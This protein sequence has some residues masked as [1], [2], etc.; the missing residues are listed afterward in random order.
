MGWKNTYLEPHSNSFTEL[1]QEWA[2]CSGS[3]IVSQRIYA[4]ESFTN[5]R[6]PAARLSTLVR[7]I[8]IPRLDSA[9]TWEYLHWQAS[10]PRRRKIHTSEI[11]WDAVR[12]LLRR[13][14][15]R[16]LAVIP[17][18]ELIWESRRAYSYTVGN[19]HSMCKEHLT[20][21]DFSRTSNWQ[22]GGVFLFFFV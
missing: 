5:I 18:Q 9:N 2:T 3:K 19:L 16:S 10:N 14:V 7:Q 21:W 13:T 20:P 17:P 6:V 11:I 8:A 15:S 1:Q 4:P 12:L 22:R